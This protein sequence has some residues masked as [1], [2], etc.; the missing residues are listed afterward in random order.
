MLFNLVLIFLVIS[1]GYADSKCIIPLILG[2]IVYL[3]IYFRN[4]IKPMYT[5]NEDSYIFLMVLNIM[6]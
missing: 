2:G 3:L 6:L 4:N 1:I 5:N